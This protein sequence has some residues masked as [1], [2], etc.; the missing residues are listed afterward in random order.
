MLALFSDR[1]CLTQIVQGQEDENDP[2]PS[3]P[4]SEAAI[5]NVLSQLFAHTLPGAE[6][7]G[8]DGESFSSSLSDYSEDEDNNANR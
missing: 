2:N 7:D 3:W 6:G 1:R 5:E 8:M 4:F